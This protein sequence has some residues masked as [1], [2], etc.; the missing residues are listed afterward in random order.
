MT[1]TKLQVRLY[2]D[3]FATPWGFRLQGGKDL[4]QPLVVQRVFCNS[5]AEGQL[6]R[7]DI[8]DSIGIR[9]GVDLSHKQ[10]QDTLKHG[11]GQIEL[12]ITRP[13]SGR[14]GITQPPANITPVQTRAPQQKPQMPQ[15]PSYGHQPKKVTVSKYG[16][17]GPSF[18]AEYAQGGVP[19]STQSRSGNY[20]PVDQY[21]MLN[22][23]QGS[24]DNI[25]LSPRTPEASP[26]QAPFYQ[27][28]QQPYEAPQQQPSY[29]QQQPYAMSTG[30]RLDRM[31]QFSEYP[32][33][34]GPAYQPQPS[35]QSRGFRST[36]ERL[37]QLE[38]EDEEN[39]VPVWERRQAF[40]GPSS[41]SHVPK[42]IKPK[43]SAPKFKKPTGPV[44][45]T[46]YSK[47]GIDY[48]QRG[49]RPSSGV[50]QPPPP[51]PQQQQQQYRQPDATSYTPSPYEDG[52]PTVP[53]WR[54]TLKTSGV[55]P[56][57]EDL[58][59]GT[60]KPAPEVH[61]APRHIKTIE[62]QLK[63]PTMKP[64]QPVKVTQKA[65]GQKG[66]V[67]APTA[68]TGERDWSQS[69]VFRMVAEQGP[70]PKPAGYGRAPQAQQAPQVQARQP[71]PPPTLPKPSSQPPQFQQNQFRTPYDD[72]VGVSDF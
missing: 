2:R 20:K 36:A 29:Q 56:W 68:P 31:Q 18:G 53:A 34:T 15:P 35:P 57:D 62:I 58:D 70:Q 67:K 63:Q 37:E 21:N 69:A 25:I 41:Y 12:A 5:P 4:N 17:G 49:S 9:R 23:V 71:P 26:S 45:G 33:Q 50:W 59:Y 48:A 64:M 40:T 16:G 6:Q 38:P 46:D 3:S 52:E 32:G 24:L 22:R 55:K 14:V 30:E 13:P 61:V 65:P 39:T 11:G 51:Q 19:V 66:P 42:P 72:E 10:A 54:H 43:R 7:G 44:I 27:P 8:I 60:R 28:Y 47:V 1:G